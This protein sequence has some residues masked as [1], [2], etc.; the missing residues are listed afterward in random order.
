[1][2]TGYFIKN[3]NVMV[4]YHTYG[5]EQ[6]VDFKLL[7]NTGMYRRGGMASIREIKRECVW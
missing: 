5:Q 3:G 6:E 1:M 7:W 2:I 4:K